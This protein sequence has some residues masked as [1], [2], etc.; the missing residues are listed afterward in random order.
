MEVLKDRYTIT[1]LSQ[2]LSVTDH[3]L[4]YY[5][6][7]FNMYV[8]KDKRG[9]RYYTPDVANIMYQ[10]KNMRDEGLE[11]KAIKKILKPEI[12]LIAP[13][14]SEENNSNSL[15]R[16]DGKNNSLEIQKFFQDFSEKLTDSFS[17]TVTTAKDDITAELNK[18][19]L[20][21]G[22]CVENNMRKF[23]S[24]MDK[25]FQNVDKSIG[26]WREKNSGGFFKKLSKKFFKKV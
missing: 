15:T 18:T 11:I 9:R 21:L 8:P 4:R 12:E 3:A 1:E 26:I 5:E 19:K 23:E 17:L 7:E 6:K 22:A 10:I 20:E 13:K 24:K 14:P 16:I 2:N 25:H